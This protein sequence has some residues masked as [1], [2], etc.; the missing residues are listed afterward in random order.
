MYIGDYDIHILDKYIVLLH[1]LAPLGFSSNTVKLWK[2]N[3]RISSVYWEFQ[4]YTSIS[5][6]IR[7]TVNIIEQD[8]EEDILVRKQTLEEIR[9]TGGSIFMGMNSTA[10]ILWTSSNRI[11][12]FVRIENICIDPV[13]NLTTHSGTLTTSHLIFIN[14]HWP[15][16]FINWINT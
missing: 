10:R 8:L 5:R 12:D 13:Y 6:T 16:I 1:M 3:L 2:F 11:Y 15:I 7:Y 4:T 9:R 14:V